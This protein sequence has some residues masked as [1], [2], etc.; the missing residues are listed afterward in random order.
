M[1]SARQNFEER[2][3]RIKHDMLKARR[4]P[5]CRLEAQSRCQ[6]W[7]T[8]SRSR[9]N[10]EN[11]D[12]AVYL[13]AHRINRSQYKLKKGAFGDLK[14]AKNTAQRQAE[15]SLDRNGSAEDIDFNQRSIS[16]M[17]ILSMPNFWK[18]ADRPQS[19]GRHISRKKDVLRKSSSAPRMFEKQVEENIDALRQSAITPTELKNHHSIAQHDDVHYLT[20]DGSRI[21]SAQAHGAAQ[22]N[23]QNFVDLINQSEIL[24]REILQTADPDQ[25]FEESVCNEVLEAQL[26]KHILQDEWLQS[27][28]QV[29]QNS[30]N[31]QHYI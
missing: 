7:K 31:L 28:G 21:S 2:V 6:S 29:Q 16:P 3:N 27:E 19:Q 22:T 9:C 26:P 25:N 17:S 4:S 20:I 30:T 10:L 23:S 5:N 13:L 15:S 11:K 24:H 12:Q 18:Q 14:K 1:S 8:N